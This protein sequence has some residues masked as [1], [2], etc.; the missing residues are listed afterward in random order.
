MRQKKDDKI[1]LYERRSLTGKVNTVFDFIHVNWQP[2]LRLTVYVLLPLSIVAGMGLVDFMVHHVFHD[3]GGEWWK[4][5]LE[6]YGVL[7]LG[8]MVANC[9]FL[10]L[11]KCYFDRSDGLESVTFKDLWCE[12][13]GVALPMLGLSVLFFAVALP[14]SSLSALT[15]F[16]APFAF[17]FYAG[18]IINPLLI[19]APVLVFNREQG[20]MPAL[21]S[22]F[23]LCYAQFWKMI[24]LMIVMLLIYFYSQSFFLGVWA[25]LS[26]VLGVFVNGRMTIATDEMVLTVAYYVAT[27]AMTLVQY[28][29]YSVLVMAVAFHY[30][31]V[32]QEQYDAG[33]E[34]EISNF[35]NL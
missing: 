19:A 4:S 26:L 34:S 14:L 28:Y 20:L 33:L 5:A 7:S 18:A 17:L 1:R 6:V 12:L 30:G 31:S 23:R 27:I 10:S 32:A 24:G 9:L 22:G 15:F 16:L 35:E 2:W 25:I 3:H 29:A 11:M 8:Y 21:K 13:R